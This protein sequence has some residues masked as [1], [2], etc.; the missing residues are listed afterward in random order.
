MTSVIE[1]KDLT[2]NYHLGNM[3]VHALRGISLKI[4]PGEFVAIM[5]ASGSGKSTLMNLLGCLD[6]PSSG[7]YLLDGHNVNSLSRNEYAEIRNQKIGFVFQGFNLLSRTTAIDNVKLPLLYDRSGA[8]RHPNDLARKAL[9][10]VG[11]GDRMDH[12]PNQLSGGEQ[13]RVAIARALVN[14]PTLILADMGR[15]SGESASQLRSESRKV[16]RDDI[17]RILCPDCRRKV[18]MTED[19]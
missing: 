15:L 7:D 12:E 6:N 1:T 4:E 16:D 17:F 19:W 11:L 9:Q 10:R 8:V 14:D 13:Q 5:G 2:K 3:V 18:F